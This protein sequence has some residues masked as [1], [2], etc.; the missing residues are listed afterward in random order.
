MQ[1]NKDVVQEALIR[2]KQ[3]ED[4]IAENAKG[5]LA[6]TMKEEINQLVKES[7][8]EQAED[9]VELDVDMDD[10]TFEEVVTL[11]LSRTSVYIGLSSL[12]VFLIGITIVFIAFTPLKYYIPGYGTR[13]GRAALQNLKIRTDSLEQVIRYNEQY[14]N[15]IKKVMEGT[16]KGLQL[17]TVS[18]SIPKAEVIND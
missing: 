10:D 12:F 3:V 13:E 8:S 11:K 4:V 15:S 17:D 6:S 1:E 18:L 7:L 2:M 5:I 14:F 16:D 9:E